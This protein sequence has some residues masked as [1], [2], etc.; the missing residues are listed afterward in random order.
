MSSFPANCS[1]LLDLSV[2]NKLSTLELQAKFLVS[3]VMAGLH[4]SPYRGFSVEF[5][6]HRAYQP[7]DD[8][9]M[10]DWKAYGRNRR[11]SVKLRDDESSMRVYLGVDV[12][13][14]MAFNGQTASMSKWKYTASLAA[15]F[16]LLL[17]KERD[18]VGLGILGRDLRFIEP[19]ASSSVMD[20]IFAEL[21]RDAN[22]V[23][24]DF[25]DSLEKMAMLVKKRSML[26]LFSDFYVAPE[27][28]ENILNHYRYF[29]CE[30]ICIHVLDPVEKELSYDS[31]QL[32]REMETDDLM[33]LN[34]D[35]IRDGY[36]KAMREHCENLRQVITGC[37]G[38]YLQLTTDEHPLTAFGAYL[39]KRRA[40]Q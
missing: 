3:G 16:A 33:A 11:F 17:Q 1:D 30:V 24:C 31:P 8:L 39:A 28:L 15:A 7:G 4:R 10:I 13:R 22:A 36:R 37:G 20:A 9:R 23:G 32:L 18:P 19:S 14:S 6:E 26:V 5:K 2:L 29:Q 25:C 21:H 38:D 34:P 40:M 27:A 35:L 12:S